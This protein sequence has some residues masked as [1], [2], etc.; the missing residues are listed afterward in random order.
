MT[1]SCFLSQHE[2]F[3]GRGKKALETCLK[4]ALDIG[5]PVV[6]VHEQD[7]NKNNCSLDICINEMPRELI[8]EP[9]LLFE[10][11]FPIPLHTADY[12]CVISLIMHFHLGHQ[13]P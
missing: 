12:Y 13:M 8:E 5:I 9:Y 11:N 3:S 10:D 1:H 7:S 4:T 6:L 2:L